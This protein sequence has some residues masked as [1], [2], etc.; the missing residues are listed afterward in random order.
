MSWVLVT[1]KLVGKRLKKFP[2]DDAQRII[3]AFEE[4]KINPY[5]GDIEKMKG[6]ENVWRR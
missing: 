5:S 1:D 3:F 2:K 4:I 6:E